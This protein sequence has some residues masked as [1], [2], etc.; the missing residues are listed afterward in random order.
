MKRADT[1]PATPTAAGNSVD[2]GVSGK[3]RTTPEALAAMFD[4]E[5][6]EA[7]TSAK[8]S[9]DFLSQL[10]IKVELNKRYGAVGKSPDVKAAP[11]TPTTPE[12]DQC[13]AMVGNPMQRCTEVAKFHYK[14]IYQCA[15][16]HARLL[17]YDPKTKQRSVEW[18][19][20]HYTPKSPD[21]KPAPATPTTPDA[22]ALQSLIAYK[23]PKADIGVWLD[24]TEDLVTKMHSEMIA[25]AVKAEREQKR[26]QAQNEGFKQALLILTNALDKANGISVDVK[27]A[28]ASHTTPDL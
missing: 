16:H 4:E 6:R 19:L 21:V 1:T 5:L 24:Y 11:E 22:T 25:L 26:L 3:S 7:F 2:V 20:N 15:K 28:P 8:E 9:G 27:P 17:A 14:G 13:Q 12:A 18:L 23:L 10:R